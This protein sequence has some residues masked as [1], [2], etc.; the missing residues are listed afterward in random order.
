[1]NIIIQVIIFTGMLFV[2][3]NHTEDIQFSSGA[4]YCISSAIMTEAE[5][6]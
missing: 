2:I 4:F 6:F 1:M 5:S 3:D